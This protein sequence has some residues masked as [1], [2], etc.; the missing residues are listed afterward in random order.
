MSDRVQ[1]IKELDNIIANTSVST[2]VR[3]AKI[4]DDL[5]IRYADIYENDPTFHQIGDMA[6]KINSSRATQGE[7]G[8]W[9]GEV[10]HLVHR[11][12]DS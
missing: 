3:S 9:W 2:E 6:I 12:G 4:V 5:L 11:L 1:L 7:D 10:I 8:V